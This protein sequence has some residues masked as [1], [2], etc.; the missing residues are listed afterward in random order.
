MIIGLF[1]YWW[2]GT[3]PWVTLP[4]H[5]KNLVFDRSQFDKPITLNVPRENS[6]KMF[7]EMRKLKVDKSRLPSIWPVNGGIY[8]I[9]KSLLNLFLNYNFAK[10]ESATMTDRFGTH[11]YR[12]LFY[13]ETLKRYILEGD[14]E[15]P[16]GSRFKIIIAFRKLKSIDYTNQYEG[17][18]PSTGAKTQFYALTFSYVIEESFPGLPHS[19]KT[20]HGKA[21]TYLDPDEGKWKLWHLK[22]EDSGSGEYIKLIDQKY[23]NQKTNSF[24]SGH[25]PAKADTKNINFEKDDEIFD[26]IKTKLK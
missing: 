4:V 19:N 5:I 18:L 9:N 16:F 12:F 26:I 22:L 7:N 23:K 25:A 1:E 21:K 8:D 3:S 15:K 14:K 20:Y 11:K 24:K 17:V 10:I 13:N 2:L 6:R